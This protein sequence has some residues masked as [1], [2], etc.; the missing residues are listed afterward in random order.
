M[1]FEGFGFP[2]QIGCQGKL[3]CGGMPDDKVT[4]SEEDGSFT[5]IRICEDCYTELH[6]WLARQDDTPEGPSP[7][8]SKRSSP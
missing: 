8:G 4:Y 2:G 3:D 7:A 6:E 1:I 5:V